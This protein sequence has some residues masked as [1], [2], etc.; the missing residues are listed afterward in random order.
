MALHSK[1][2]IKPTFES[3]PP[4]FSVFGILEMNKIELDNETIARALMQPAGYSL[5]E[6]MTC[7]GPFDLQLV[8][9]KANLCRMQDC[10]SQRWQETEFCEPCWTARANL[11]ASPP[12]D[13]SLD[14]WTSDYYQ[15]PEGAE[16]MQDLIEHRNMN[17]A[18]GNVFKA[19]YRYGEKDGTTM[20]Y[21]LYKII[22]YAKRELNRIL[23]CQPESPL[24]PTMIDTT[25]LPRPRS[26]ALRE[27][28]PGETL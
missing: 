1:S 28:E 11:P 14:G 5:G 25:V 3:G 9:R 4:L 10:S 12:A 17:F 13:A 21:D 22:W 8:K 2:D 19:C 18:M 23:K 15:L 16:E 27:I 26:S 24:K 6:Y 7:E 20:E